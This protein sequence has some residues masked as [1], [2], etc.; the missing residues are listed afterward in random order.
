MGRQSLT[1]AVLPQYRNRG[2]GGQL[3]AQLLGAAAHT[4]PTVSLSVAAGNPAR[5]LYE[6]HG[7]HPLD[8]NGD[9]LTMVRHFGEPPDLAAISSA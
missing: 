8:P 4:Y 3:L 6:R 1:I 9:S 5:R 2:I 7:F